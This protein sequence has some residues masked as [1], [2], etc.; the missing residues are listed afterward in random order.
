MVYQIKENTNK[1]N[2]SYAQVHKVESTEDTYIENTNEEYDHLHNIGGR[3]LNAS[4]NTYSS[5]AG[6]RNR[7]DPTYD[8]ATSST[9]VDRNNTYDHSFTN[10]KTYS[11]YNV[12]DSCTQIGGTNYDAYDQTC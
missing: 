12:S 2:D 11:E 6:V 1:R 10:M 9:R 3:K 8:T 5:S 4:E 7:S